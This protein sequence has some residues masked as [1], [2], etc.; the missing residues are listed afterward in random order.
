MK[1]TES[2]HSE[3]LNQDVTMARWG[4]VGTPVLMFATA[5]GDAEEIERFHLID[6]LGPLLEAGR[7]KVYSCDSMAGRAMLRSDGNP[8]Y[9]MWMQN[10]FHAH[11]YHEVVPAI[12]TDC[13]TPDIGIIAAGSS[14]GAFNALAMVCRYPDVFTDALCVSGTY[15]LLRFHK[16]QPTR[17]FLVSSPIHFLPALDGSQLDQIRKRFVLIACGRG[18]AEDIDESWRLAHLLGS[19][20]IPNR[21]D[22]WGPDWHHDWITWR[23]MFPKYLDELTRGG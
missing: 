16:A 8:E 7:I 5:G 15:D 18:N 1:A 19:K 4:A 20:G 21:M 22:D 12:R 3:R 2:W 10:R 14:I 23:E 13:R 6:A 9:R 17:D 11:I